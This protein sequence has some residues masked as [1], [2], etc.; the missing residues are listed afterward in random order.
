MG[1]IRRWF[2][3]QALRDKAISEELVIEKGSIAI[4]F[5]QYCD[6]LNKKGFPR[7]KSGAMLDTWDLYDYFLK[8]KEF[9]TFYNHAK[10]YFIVK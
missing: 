4:A 10:K 9:D 3:K 5:T 6:S 1:W 2:Y 8:S 7:K